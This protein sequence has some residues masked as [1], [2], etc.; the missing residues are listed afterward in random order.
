LGEAAIGR[1]LSPVF[2]VAV[3]V[4]LGLTVAFF[5]VAVF[6][7]FLFPNPTMSESAAVTW[8]FGAAS[9]SLTA[10]LGLFAGKLA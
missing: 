7:S 2:K 8:L 5:V 1:S 4:M 10:L 9:S 3:F 6:L